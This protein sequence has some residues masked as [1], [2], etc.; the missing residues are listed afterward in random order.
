MC[1]DFVWSTS[2]KGISL[3][4]GEEGGS[5]FLVIDPKKS[6][7]KD[8]VDSREII[9]LKD[10]RMLCA[11]AR[12]Q[13]ICTKDTLRVDLLII[14]IILLYMCTKDLCTAR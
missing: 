10:A 12:S 9:G 5:I 2:L 3:G 11:T 4:K 14:V 13:A 1:S 6:S 8:Y 7:S